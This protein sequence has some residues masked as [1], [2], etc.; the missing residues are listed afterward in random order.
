MQY[1]KIY[2]CDILPYLKCRLH[3]AMRP[4]WAPNILCIFIYCTSWV[5]AA[6]HKCHT[7]FSFC[8]WVLRRHYKKFYSRSRP[9]G[10]LPGGQSLTG[11]VLIEDDGC[12]AFPSTIMADKTI[13]LIMASRGF[14]EVP[15]FR[16]NVPNFVSYYSE[17]GVR[18]AAIS[19][20]RNSGRFL[21]HL[22]GLSQA[23]GTCLN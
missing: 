9:K 8:A 13:Q 1:F 11:T 18:A 17:I 12:L 22:L 20:P 15:V 4:P 7:T 14:W 21:K 23:R 2:R 16:T 6:L 10:S 19:S 3:I 5:L